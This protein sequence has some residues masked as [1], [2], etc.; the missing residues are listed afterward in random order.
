MKQI[1]EIL[2][3]KVCKLL[4]TLMSVVLLLRLELHFHAPMRALVYVWWQVCHVSVMGTDRSKA[5]ILSMMVR[6]FLLV[7]ENGTDCWGTLASTTTPSMSMVRF[8]NSFRGEAYLSVNF[9]CT[10]VY[11]LDV[12]Q[13][14]FVLY[15]NFL[16]YR[17]NSPPWVWLPVRLSARHHY[18]QVTILFLIY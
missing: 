5:L 17:R 10:S 2:F 9:N 13:T 8:F 7:G 4:M 14:F 6:E 16:N 18:K 1:G 3:L 11:E 15:C 12:R